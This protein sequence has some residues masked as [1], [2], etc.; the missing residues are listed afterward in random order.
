MKFSEFRRYQPKPGQNVFVFVCEDDFLVE[1]SRA[2]WLRIFGGSWVF[3]KYA[4]KEFEEIPAARLM[5]D[6]LTPS[7]FTQN[8]ALLVTNAEKLTKGRIEHLTALQNVA[9][10]SLKVV[11]ATAGRKSADA[12]A[13]V[14]PIVE[15]DSLRPA[16]VARWLVDRYK[17]TPEIARYLVD[18]V[19]T[20]LYP[21]HTEIEKLKTYVGDARPIEARD[22]DVLILRSEQF[23]P[24]EMDDAIVARD[25]T[26]AVQ[27]L[28]AMLGEGM[29]PLI[30]L[31]RIVRVWRQLFVGKS[32]VGK[33]SANDVAAA[34]LVP[35]WKAAD[36]AAACRKFEWKQLAAGFPLLLQADRALKTSTP[37]PE[38]YFDV[39][40][41]KLIG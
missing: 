29:D 21:L 34:A 1:E 15:I 30:I 16:D 20:D 17:L 2:V 38:G 25:Y 8:R 40:L 4:A 19:G 36:F 23:G 28:G 5:D 41:W 37:N 6:A 22:I 9:N 13:K 35:V 7:L 3:D 33:R 39:L 24:F 31:S 12:W 10:A 11:L 32:L 14:F 18:N 27:V 26:K